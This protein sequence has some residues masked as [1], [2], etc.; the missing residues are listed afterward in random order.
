MKPRSRLL[1]MIVLSWVP[2]L[3]VLGNAVLIP[4]M[5]ELQRH[6]SVNKFQTSLLITLFSVSA[7]TVIPFA[8]FLSDQIPRKFIIV[9]AVLIFGLGGVLAGTASWWMPH[10]YSTVVIARMIQGI[11]AA[12]TGPIAMALVG[13]I[14]QGTARSRALGFNEAGNAFGK[15]VSP[16]I[17]SAVALLAWF[18]VF[19]VFPLLCL[20]LAAAL[21][22][23]VPDQTSMKKNQNGMRE[24][25][26][27]VKSIFQTEG[28]WLA[29]A[30]LAGA[31]ALFS[32]F[33]ILFYLSDLLET[34]YH[35]KGMT[36][37]LVLA[38]PIS[39]L[40]V[41]S[42]LMGVVIKRKTLLMKWLLITGFLLLGA[43]TMTAIWLARS[44]WV[45]I[46]LM[47]IGAVGTGTILPSLNMLIT[48]AVGSD[49]RGVITSFYGAVRFWGVAAG[50]P[51]FTWLQGIS[52]QVM[53]GAV[54]VLAFSCSF[55]VG[56]LIQPFSG[57]PQDR[58]LSDK[59]WKAETRQRSRF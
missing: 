27:S 16:M 34:A 55:L 38:I 3:M 8:G 7:G 30:Y 15:V 47:S 23:F 37:G 26:E 1:T 39:M 33:G 28:R 14:F 22:W 59:C 41:T 31:I 25:W 53:F 32:L 51:V 49:K 10:P 44:V 11:G 29:V 58:A 43:T 13:D 56:G 9:P 12:G 35:M 42:L 52:T 20:P 19:F 57:Q 24:Y 4:V 5:P 50:P 2:F 54:G 6:L 46:A 17:G 48:S 36:R 45:L 18:G 40:T 21:W